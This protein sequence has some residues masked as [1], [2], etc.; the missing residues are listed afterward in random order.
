MAV[1]GLCYVRHVVAAAA[2]DLV[3]L[4]IIAC[5]DRI[6]ALVAAQQVLA[7]ATVHGIT[8]RACV[9]I[10]CASKGAYSIV[11]LT[12]PDLIVAGRAVECVIATRAD[13]DRRVGRYAYGKYVRKR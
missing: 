2:P 7:L 1:I 9:N 8:P 3:A 10:I 5:I 12:A 4:G 11:A 6:V 13:N